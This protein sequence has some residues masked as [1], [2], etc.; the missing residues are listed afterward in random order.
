MELE[1]DI[2]EKLQEELMRENHE[3]N[4]SISAF[5]SLI[6]TGQDLVVLADEIIFVLFDGKNVCPD[7][8]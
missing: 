4:L 2:L 5:I 6:K 3:K 1:K 7:S 8:R